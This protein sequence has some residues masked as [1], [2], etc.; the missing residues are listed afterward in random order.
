MVILFKTQV[1]S[2]VILEN[3]NNRLAS[4]SPWLFWNAEFITVFTRACHKSQMNPSPLKSENQ[5]PVRC[6]SHSDVKISA[7]SKSFR[8]KNYPGYTEGKSGLKHG[9][10]MCISCD[11]LHAEVTFD[12]NAMVK[13]Q[14][15]G[16]R[17]G[18]R[19]TERREPTVFYSGTRV[20]EPCGP[21]N[22]LTANQSLP[23]L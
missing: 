22:P 9:I 14:G 13:V 17:Q 6:N 7:L 4:K 16:Q 19:E 1:L 8:K 5:L 2:T 20:C 12:C 3:I 18:E 15:G 21:E 11:A 23:H 10:R